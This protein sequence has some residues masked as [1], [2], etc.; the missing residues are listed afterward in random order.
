MA[1]YLGLANETPE[2]T[3]TMGSLP[4]TCVLGPNYFSQG[5]QDT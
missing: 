1:S 4:V 2:R 3:D 5:N